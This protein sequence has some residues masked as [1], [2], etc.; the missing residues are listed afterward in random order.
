ML[1]ICT[2]SLKWWDELKIV[3]FLMTEVATGDVP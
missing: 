1:N 3:N 2:F